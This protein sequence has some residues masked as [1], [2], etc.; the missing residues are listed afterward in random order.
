[1]AD[2]NNMQYDQCMITATSLIDRLRADGHRITAGRK[3]VVELLTRH[4][5][6]LGALEVQTLLEAKKT[7]VNLTTAYRELQ[8]LAEQGIVKTVQFNDGVQRYELSGLPHH[9]HLVCKS[10]KNVEDIAMEHDLA[11]MEK[12]IARSKGFNVTEHALE[13]YGTC[14]NC[15]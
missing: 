6:P 8:F 9:H 5:K 3:A 7:P 13:F 1:M 15:R 10:C 11:R 14:R 4:T 2:A 12:T